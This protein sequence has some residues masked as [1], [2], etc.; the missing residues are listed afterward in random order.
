MWPQKYFCQTKRHFR[1]FVFQNFFFSYFWLLIFCFSFHIQNA[2]LELNKSFP[3]VC[4]SAISFLPKKTSWYMQIVVSLRNLC[5][6]STLF[7]WAIIKD[8]VRARWKKRARN[9]EFKSNVVCFNTYCYTYGVSHIT[10]CNKYNTNLNLFTV[11]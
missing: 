10:N 5:F 11:E 1:S 8:L 9:I 3:V 6:L 2:L 4:L 7:S